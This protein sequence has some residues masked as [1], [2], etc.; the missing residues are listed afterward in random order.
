MPKT[1][2]KQKFAAQTS[3]IKF[4]LWDGKAKE[5]HGIPD[6]YISRDGWIT[7]RFQPR[8][9]KDIADKVLYKEDPE[10]RNHVYKEFDIS[11]PKP[12]LSRD[13]FGRNYRGE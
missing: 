10:L 3:T 1:F 8:T 2:K 12:T 7:R 5:N 11:K 6:N 13:L 4:Y 9:L